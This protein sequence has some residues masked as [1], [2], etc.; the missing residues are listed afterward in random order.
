VVECI[1]RHGDVDVSW[2]EELVNPDA[3]GRSLSVDGAWNGRLEAQGFVD[4]GVEIGERFHGIVGPGCIAGG[5]EGVEQRLQVCIDL[6]M[7]DEVVNCVD[8]GYGRRVARWGGMLVGGESGKEKRKE[9]LRV[10]NLPA[11]ITSLESSAM[12]TGSA[13]FQYPVD[14]SLTVLSLRSQEKISVGV[15]S[16]S[17]FLTD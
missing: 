17:Q 14:S 10:T 15:A 5:E 9:K 7:L 13:D 16:G 12:A 8:E 2:D 4:D 3:L 11:M 1:R 6:G